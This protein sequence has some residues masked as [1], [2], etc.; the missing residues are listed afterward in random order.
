MD[1]GAATLI[2]FKYTGID[3]A[4]ATNTAGK[5]QAIGKRNSRMGRLRSQHELSTVIVLVLMQ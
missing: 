1:L 5:I 3:A 4:S 2:V